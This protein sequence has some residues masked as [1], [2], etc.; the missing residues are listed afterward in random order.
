MTPIRTV[1]EE[2]RSKGTKSCGWCPVAAECTTLFPFSIGWLIT[3]RFRAIGWVGYGRVAIDP[4]GRYGR[5]V[6]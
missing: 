3:L 1:L 4:G 2:C 5:G 6:H